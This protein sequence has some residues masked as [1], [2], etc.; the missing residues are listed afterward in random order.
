MMERFELFSSPVINRVGNRVPA[1]RGP[2]FLALSVRA[3]IGIDNGKIVVELAKSTQLISH[4]GFLEECR[5]R[6]RL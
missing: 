6:Y 2:S 3:V 4:S 5:R 1:S